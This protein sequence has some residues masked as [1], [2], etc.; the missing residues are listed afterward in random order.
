MQPETDFPVKKTNNNIKSNSE[1]EHRP[2]RRKR[3]PS[4]YSS[5]DTKKMRKEEIDYKTKTSELLDD[6]FVNGK[7][8]CLYCSDDKYLASK[9]RLA[10]HITKYHAY[11][12]SEC[13][14]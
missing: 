1:I 3:V 12:C 11:D 14:K 7:I 10:I 13:E 5:S 4:K 9:H 8:K 2:L 6:H